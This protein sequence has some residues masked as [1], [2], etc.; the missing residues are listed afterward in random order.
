VA[1]FDWPGLPLS[2]HSPSSADKGEAAA[3]GGRQARSVLWLGALALGGVAVFPVAFVGAFLLAV[4]FR[5][6]SFLATV[7]FMVGV[8]VVWS[9]IQVARAPLAEPPVVVLPVSEAPELHRMIEELAGTLGVSPPSRIAV[10]PVAWPQV[11]GGNG[12]L[13]I[14]ACWL[15]CLTVRELRQ[16]LAPCVALVPAMRRRD[17][18]AAYRLAHRVDAAHAPHLNRLVRRPLVSLQAAL[19]K[20]VSALDGVLGEWAH[21]RA[22]AV[23]VDDS[24]ADRW[25]ADFA[26]GA[27]S[28]FLDRFVVDAWI[29]GVAPRAL[30]IGVCEFASAHVGAGL[31]EG[32]PVY[33]RG[34]A[35]ATTLLLDP[36]HVDELVSMAA[37]AQVGGGP[38]RP[39]EWSDY[40]A[41]VVDPERRRQASALI[42]AVDRVEGRTGPASLARVLSCLEAGGRAALAADLSA[43]AQGETAQ[44]RSERMVSTLHQHIWGLLSC[45]L[46]D[47]GIA[48]DH[49]GWTYGHCLV[50]GD[51]VVDLS[52]QL[53]IASSSGNPS[54]L[55]LALSELGSDSMR[56][57]WIAGQ[58]AA[59]PRMLWAKAGVRYRRKAH[60]IV[61]CEDRLLLLF[62]G[63]GV[64]LRAGLDSYVGSRTADHLRLR[65]ILRSNVDELVAAS[66]RNEVLLARD[67]VGV[68]VKTNRLF[69]TWSI[70]IRMADREVVLHNALYGIDPPGPLVAQL[71]ALFGDRLV[72]PPRLRVASSAEVSG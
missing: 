18:A 49:L 45:A 43:N 60:D 59:A 23:R 2:R 28:L 21:E 44:Q 35:P 54:A 7:T 16:A 39:I 26:A 29:I 36:S 14:P 41:E 42:S 48:T 22:S 12:G 47:E 37:S 25:Q 63:S 32:V 72:A 65:A 5:V 70:T 52:A 71:A 64:D 62:A 3:P 55:R 8:I 67:V 11:L 66:P 56:P 9:A 69:G 6:P 53:H 31:V 30:G 38:R 61:V 13:V 68:T 51:L 27:W 17:I 50:H 15:W 34:D 20:R 58:E 19:A 10:A 33:R 57:V 1:P 40:I 46:V 4:K 24:D